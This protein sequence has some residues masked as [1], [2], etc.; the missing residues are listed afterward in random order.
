VLRVFDGLV[1]ADAITIIALIGKNGARSPRGL[2]GVGLVD[3]GA[4]A[5]ANGDSA[6]VGPFRW[7]AAVVFG[8]VEHLQR[9]SFGA[10]MGEVIA[11]G[12]DVLANSLCEV[13]GDI[14]A[15]E[16]LGVHALG[17]RVGGAGRWQLHLGS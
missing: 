5:E 13:D 12:V 14:L 3:S 17:S 15:Q 11:E 2:V 7:Q 16:A 6:R 1:E 9:N 8:I 10:L 4:G